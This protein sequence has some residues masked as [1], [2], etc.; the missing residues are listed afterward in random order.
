MVQRLLLQFA[1]IATHRGS[2]LSNFS[3]ALVEALGQKNRGD[4]DGEAW[5]SWQCACSYDNWVSR[6]HCY[7]CGLDWRSCGF[8]SGFET[9]DEDE[10]VEAD[11]ASP[12]TVFC[13][14]ATSG[15]DEPAE[16]S[17]SSP[18]GRL[19]PRDEQV[20]ADRASPSTVPCCVA[21]SGGDEPAAPSGSSTTGRLEPCAGVFEPR[22]EASSSGLKGQPRKKIPSRV[23][24]DSTEHLGQC[25]AGHVLKPFRTPTATFICD[26]CEITLPAGAGLNGCRTCN[27]DLCALCHLRSSTPSGRT[28]LVEAAKAR[29]AEELDVSRLWGARVAMEDKLFVFVMLSEHANEERRQREEEEKRLETLSLL[30]KAR[31]L[32]EA[33]EAKCLAFLVLA[34]HAEEGRRQKDRETDENALVTEED[35]LGKLWER[36]TAAV[37]AERRQA[38]K[39]RLAHELLEAGPFTALVCPA[40]HDIGLKLKRIQDFEAN[41]LQYVA[42]AVMY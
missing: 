19:D 26:G 15:G 6:T 28:S 10:Q 33:K 39:E 18:T 5:N 7:S 3:K 11:K 2:Q 29:K 37:E 20:E 17:G 21:S 32:R 41:T 31:L 36:A 14:V 4:D 13:C 30:S 8:G 35:R 42:G 23:A 22:S 25:P 16:P 34:K 12:S 24:E 38:E 27:Y 40:N 1:E 9:S